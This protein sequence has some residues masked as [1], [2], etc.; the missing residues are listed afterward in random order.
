MLLSC[1][2][3][4]KAAIPCARRGNRIGATR[5]GEP[6]GSGSTIGGCRASRALAAD[7][8]RAYSRARPGE[9]AGRTGELVVTKEQIAAFSSL[10]RRSWT[11]CGRRKGDG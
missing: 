10:P 7:S 9:S 11:P 6:D 8:G 4:S 2:P 1:W 3:G 5:L